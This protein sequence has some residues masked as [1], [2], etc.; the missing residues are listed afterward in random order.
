MSRLSL[1]QMVLSA[2]LVMIRSSLREINRPFLS[3][4]PPM[5]TD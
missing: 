2:K 3:P 5:D 1:V 4:N